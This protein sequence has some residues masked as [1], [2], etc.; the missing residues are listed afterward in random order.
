MIHNSLGSCL[1]AGITSC[2]DDCIGFP[3]T[4]HCDTSC[5]NYGDCCSDAA[6]LCDNLARKCLMMSQSLLFGPLT[7]FSII[8]TNYT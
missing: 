3:T 4:C 1:A 2:C 8:A 6:L 5:K 7:N